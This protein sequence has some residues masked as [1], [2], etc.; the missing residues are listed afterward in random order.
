MFTNDDLVLQR[1]AKLHMPPF[2]RKKEEGIGKMLNQD[3]IAKTWSIASL[4][5]HVE[6]AIQRM[7]TFNFFS[8][9][10]ECT[11]WS[12]IDYTIVIVAVLCTNFVVL[13]LSPEGHGIP[14]SEL[15]PCL[16][17]EALDG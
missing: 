10:V 4:R 16:T 12:L 7:K 5:I 15:V 2:N 8:E 1:D 9:T 17:Y 3:E 11:L 6:R 13:F 14:K